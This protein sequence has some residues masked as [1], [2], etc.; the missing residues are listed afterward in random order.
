MQLLP[1]CRD[2]PSNA[3]LPARSKASFEIIYTPNQRVWDVATTKLWRA[4][5]LKAHDAV[6]PHSWCAH[7]SDE[8]VL[9]ILYKL[10]KTELNMSQVRP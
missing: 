8:V 7:R 1:G 9:P 2:G 3:A 5:F 6:R 4:T 10:D